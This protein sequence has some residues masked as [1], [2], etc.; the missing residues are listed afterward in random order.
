M[1]NNPVVSNNYTSINPDY[2]VEAED[3]GAGVLRQVVRVANADP[4]V[5]YRP[6]DREVGTPSYYGFLATDGNW[7]ILKDTNTAQRYA[8]GTSDYT[9]NWTNRAALT[10]DYLDVVFA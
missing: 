10:Y 8:A 2:K 5:R 7:Y 3:Q 9:T 6:S 4:L 1:S